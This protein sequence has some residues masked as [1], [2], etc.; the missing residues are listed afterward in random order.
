M[1]RKMSTGVLVAVILGA[2]IVVIGIVAIGLFALRG[3]VTGDQKTEVGIA[4]ANK[5]KGTAVTHYVEGGGRAL[6][7]MDM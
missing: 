7:V 3:Q 5:L 6:P 4:N 1:E 2:V